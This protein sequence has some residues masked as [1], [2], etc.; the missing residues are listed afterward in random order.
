MVPEVQSCS[1]FLVFHPLCI[2]IP[3]WSNLM[4]V[5]WALSMA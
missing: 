3:V 2:C 5:Q 1:D 4:S